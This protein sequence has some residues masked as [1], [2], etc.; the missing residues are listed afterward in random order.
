MEWD[1]KTPNPVGRV[2]ILPIRIYATVR[3]MPLAAPY[4]DSGW[5]EEY[6]LSSTTAGITEEA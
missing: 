4:I 1:E 3:L 5:G 6:I 2:S